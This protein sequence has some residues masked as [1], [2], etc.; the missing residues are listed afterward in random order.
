MLIS[1]LI[2]P[3][4]SLKLSF[5]VI[6]VD[7]TISDVSFLLI[8]TK[9]DLGPESLSLKNGS[10]AVLWVKVKLP[11]EDAVVPVVVMFPETLL[12]EPIVPV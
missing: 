7:N 8:L 5:T 1:N 6:G 10:P 9:N 11:I 3:T 12:A 4:G 2:S